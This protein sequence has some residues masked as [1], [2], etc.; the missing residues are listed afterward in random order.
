MEAPSGSTDG[1]VMWRGQLRRRLGGLEAQARRLKSE[2]A[3]ERL[4]Q[5]AEFEQAGTIMMYMSLASEVDTR[6]AIERALA[7]GKT[8]VVGKVVG[9]DCQIE[10]VRLSSLHEAMARD[11]Y[12]VRYPEDATSVDV[13]AIDLVVVPGLGF[14]GTG[15][16]LG[17]GG[18]YYDRF[19]NTVSLRALRCGLAFA[20]Q[21]LE[22][23]PVDEHD[24]PV[25]LLVTDEQTH[26][27]VD[28]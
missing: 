16:R 23:I 5:L 25:H 26:R 17:R 28:R 13:G 7:A 1:K 8:V 15:N 2:A 22:H 20:E 12:G 6:P 14:D 3:C 24:Q 19:L 9:Q 4:C 21:V 18:G 11:Q 10:A 27:F